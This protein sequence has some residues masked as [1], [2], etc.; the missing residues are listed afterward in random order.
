MIWPTTSHPFGWG[1]YSVFAGV[2]DPLCPR[3]SY[4]LGNELHAKRR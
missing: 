3:A 4:G 1:N 2:R